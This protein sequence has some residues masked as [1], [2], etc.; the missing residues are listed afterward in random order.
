M[1]EETTSFLIKEIPLRIWNKFKD[2]IPRTTTLNDAML[3]LIKK[4]V[5]Q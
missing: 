4:E 3:E 5:S 1:E 2:K